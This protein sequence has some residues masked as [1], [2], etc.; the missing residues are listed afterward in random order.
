MTD[1][2]KNQLKRLLRNLFQFDSADLDF[3]IYKK[4]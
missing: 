1:D 4:I 3:G 2:Y